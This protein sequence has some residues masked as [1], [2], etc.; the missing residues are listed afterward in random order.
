MKKRKLISA[1]FLASM[2]FSLAG[3]TSELGGHNVKI[4]QST[5]SP[6]II[7]TYN[8]DGQKID[9]LK[10]GSIEIEDDKKLDP[11]IDITYG[12][13]KLIHTSSTLIAYEGLHNYM[14][15][16]RTWQS[17][18]QNQN[19]IA[20]K[21][22][23]SLASIYEHTPDA[24]HNKD[25]NVVI[26]KSQDGTPIGVFVGQKVKICQIGESDFPN[27]IITIDGH[28]LFVY[29]CSYTTY[30]ITALQA[31][32]KSDKVNAIKHQSNVKTE[33]TPAVGTKEK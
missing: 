14:D 2:I 22:K 4:N 15:N 27:S 11:A 24:F 25:R 17:Q 18:L 32:A 29:D 20:N 33:D 21:A 7:D 13:N 3:C 16:Y 1:V 31:M 12:N 10:T 26:I 19:I 6:I 28:Q 30:P 9:Q 8:N 5:A 23:P